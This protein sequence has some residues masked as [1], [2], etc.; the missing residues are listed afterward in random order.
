MKDTVIIFDGVCNLCNRLINFILKWD[1]YKKFK[2]A[3]LQ[4]EFGQGFIKE[5]QGSLNKLDTVILVKNKQVFEKSD[6][7]LEILK[8]LNGFWRTFL[9][10]KIVPKK[11]RDSV[12]K[13]I[14]DNRY[15]WF[16]MQQRCL[17]P[18]WEIRDRFII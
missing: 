4:S 8:E 14:A 12:Y 18:G 15:H 2:F 16:G 17:V 9:I 7:V 1:K 3:W 13:Y 6:A 10:F 5:T 11:F